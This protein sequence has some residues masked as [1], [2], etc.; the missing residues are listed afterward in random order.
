MW[1]RSQWKNGLFKCDSFETQTNCVYG[2]TT[3]GKCVCLGYYSTQEK[4]LKVL[5]MLSEHTGSKYPF[6][7][8]QDSEVD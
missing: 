8:P 7:I 6:F 1:V 2:T 5:D 4:A 3:Y